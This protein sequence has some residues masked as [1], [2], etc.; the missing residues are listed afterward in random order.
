MHRSAGVSLQWHAGGAVNESQRFDISWRCRN[1]GSTG[2]VE[3]AYSNRESIACSTCGA[4]SNALELDTVLRPAGFLTDFFAAPSND[5]SSQTYVPVQEPRVSVRGEAVAFPDASCGYFVFG[6]E[7]HVFHHSRGEHENGYAVCMACG[8]ADSM[9]ANNEV[10]VALKPGTFHRPLQGGVGKDAASCS[11]E[12]VKKNV[13]LGYQF[14]TDVLEICLKSPRTGEWLGVGVDPKLAGATLGLALRE[15]VA[16]RLG[17]AST[18]IDFA[19]R[20]DKDPA[21]GRARTVIQLFDRVSGGAGFVLAGVSELA[22]LMSE[23]RERLECPADCETVCTQCLA[24][25]DSQ[26]ERRALDRHQAIAWFDQAGVMEHLRLSS[27]FDPIQGAKYCSL[28]PR[29]FVAGRVAKGVRELRFFLGGEPVDWDLSSAGFRSRLLKW[30]VVDKLDVELSVPESAKLQEETRRGLSG[31]AE[32]GIR[33]SR[34]MRAPSGPMLVLQAVSDSGVST[35][36]SDRD[37]PSLPGELWLAGDTESRL[38]STERVSLLPTTA[39]DTSTWGTAPAGVVKL[40]VRYE[41]DGALSDFGKRLLRL[42][43]QQAPKAFEQ[44]Q[45]DDLESVAYSDR[46]LKS[47]W[48]LMLLAETLRSLV[49]GAAVPLTVDAMLGD[50]RGY[51][52]RI[53]NDWSIASVQTAT[54]QTWL[55]QVGFASV[56]VR[57]ASNKRDMPHHRTLLLKYRSRAEVTID[58]DQGMGYW[59]ARLDRQFNTYNEEAGAASRES[60]MKRAHEKARVSGSGISFTPI[61]VEVRNP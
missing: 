39:V 37:T 35:L 6:H 40:K 45:Q 43:A 33:I 10:P 42:I 31:L 22:L 16:S 18:E 21:T 12:A 11:A 17:I 52:G 60:Q 56:Q 19:T 25:S 15:V 1:C 27:E 28:D 57:L 30:R 9:S 41:L 48:A 7:G 14:L 3:N 24:G 58:F 55:K 38:V 2:L 34:Y 51:R 13:F 4:A 5:V 32:M 50:P 49:R 8:R 44:L 61:Y 53:D 59:G 26:V 47:P 46:Y 36:Y 20:Q 23:A 29:R 54:I